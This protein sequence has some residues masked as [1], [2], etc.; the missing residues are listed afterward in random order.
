M[1]VLNLWCTDKVLKQRVASRIEY[2]L[3]TNRKSVA[4]INPELNKGDRFNDEIDLTTN[5][6]VVM[7][8]K[9]VMTGEPK[10]TYAAYYNTV[11]YQVIDVLITTSGITHKHLDEKLCKDLFALAGE[12]TIDLALKEGKVRDTVRDIEELIYQRL[13]LTTSNSLDSTRKKGQKASED[14][15]DVI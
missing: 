9:P 6:D 5:C 4:R 1:L 15:A 2:N 14:E 3:A 7:Q 8:E 12:Q 13:R 10:S 11:D